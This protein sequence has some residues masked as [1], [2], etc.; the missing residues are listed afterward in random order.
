MIVTGVARSPGGFSIAMVDASRKA[1]G[2]ITLAFS[3]NPIALKQWSVVDAQGGH[4]SVR[5]TGLRAVPRLDE[6]LFALPD[7]NAHPIR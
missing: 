4:T 3:D 1:P 6:G 2:Q 5:L 7:P